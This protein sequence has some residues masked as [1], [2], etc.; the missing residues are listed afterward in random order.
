VALVCATSGEDSEGDGMVMVSPQEVHFTLPP[1]HSARAW[2]VFPQVQEN[3]MD[4]LS[5]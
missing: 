2:K 4:S 1:A 3:R 5:V